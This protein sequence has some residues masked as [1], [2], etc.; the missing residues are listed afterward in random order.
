MLPD[1]KCALLCGAERRGAGA[2]TA[3]HHLFPQVM[4]L[5]LEPTVL[6]THRDAQR[7]QTLLDPAGDKFESNVCISWR[8]NLKEGTSTSYL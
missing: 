5:R 3:G 6:Y 1:V 2:D 7:G 4:D 8:K